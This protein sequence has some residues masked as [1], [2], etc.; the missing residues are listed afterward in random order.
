V[1]QQDSQTAIQIARSTME[2][3]F[4]MTALTRLSFEITNETKTLG[5][6]TLKDGNA[7]KNIAVL[8]TVLLPG[9]YVAVSTACKY[10][11]TSRF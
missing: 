6:A 4:Q 2:E 9:I 10:P 7:M 11:S 8:K 5:I 1:P 3:I